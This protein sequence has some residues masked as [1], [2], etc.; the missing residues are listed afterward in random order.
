M[1][2]LSV[3]LLLVPLVGSARM[4]PQTVP[5]PAVCWDSFEEAINYHKHI[6]KEHPIGRGVVNHP[7]GPTF[8][9]ITVNPTKPSWSI[10]HFHLNLETGR[11]LVCAMSGGKEWEVIIPDF[12]V[13]EEIEI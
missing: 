9:T 12:G 13:E 10:L 4:F 7:D 8:A 2:K 5:V 3:L 1:K 6:L 11:K